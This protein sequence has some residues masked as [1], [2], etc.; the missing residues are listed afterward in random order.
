MR[1]SWICALVVAVFASSVLA[2]DFRPRLTIPPIAC[3]PR[4]M[5]RQASSFLQPL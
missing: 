3:R 2:Q 1:S 5:G 4:P